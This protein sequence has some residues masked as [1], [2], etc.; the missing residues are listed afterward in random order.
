MSNVKL[1]NFDQLQSALESIKVYIDEAS[2]KQSLITRTVSN[3]T[4]TLTTDPNQ[5][6]VVNSNITLTLPSVTEFTEIRLFMVWNNG[7]SI[8]MP[9]NV[10]WQDGTAYGDSGTY[11]FIF[12]YVNSTIGWLA[13]CVVYE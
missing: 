6:A 8:T 4:L 13:G 12:T 7:I 5:Y 1:I 3:K 9:K 10:K 2:P 11:E